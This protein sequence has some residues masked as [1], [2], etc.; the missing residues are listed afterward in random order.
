LTIVILAGGKSQR[1]GNDKAFLPYKR[2]TFISAIVSEML[3]IS[4]DIIV[5]IGAKNPSR[6]MEEIVDKRVRF[7][8]DRRYISN[9]L[10]G[11]LTGFE[12][13]TSRYAAVIACDL[14]LVKKELI[15]ALFAAAE[16]HDAAVPI[17]NPKDKFSTEPLCAVYNVQSMIRTI[18]HSLSKGEFGCKRVVMALGDLNCIPVARLRECDPEL[19]SLKNINTKEDYL[20][21]LEGLKLS[22]TSSRPAVRVKRPQIPGYARPRGITEELHTG[23]HV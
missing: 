18:N 8:K 9:P 2:N 10:G 6:F 14:P 7:V 19:D 23:S 13:A 4:D 12:L 1:M 16:G 5:V 21:L 11:M 20:D 3:Y 22:A 15:L 17:W